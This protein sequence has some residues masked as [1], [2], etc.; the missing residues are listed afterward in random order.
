MPHHSCLGLFWTA[1]PLILDAVRGI[2][3]DNLSK[4][5][6]LL[7][8]LKQ[9]SW[10]GKNANDRLV[11]FTERIATV[12]WLAS[13]LKKDMGVSDAAIAQMHGSGI[14]MFALHLT[15][16]VLGRMSEAEV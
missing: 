5:G 11:I 16:E 2:E 3:K 6:K 13:N 9:I 14:R 1:G 7:E 10:T 8:L 15:T 4:F 12:K